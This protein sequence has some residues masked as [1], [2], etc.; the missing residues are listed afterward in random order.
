MVK[1]QNTIKKWL[2]ELT[3]FLLYQIS[4][5]YFYTTKRD[6]FF[7]LKQL[8]KKKKSGPNWSNLTQKNNQTFVGI[9]KT[10]T[11]NVLLILAYI[12]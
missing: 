1:D 11:P 4:N 8:G 2:F 10:L 6:F 7:Y 9:P 12:R 3:F 5:G